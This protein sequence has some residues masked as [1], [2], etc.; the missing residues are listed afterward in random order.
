MPKE[1]FFLQG[2]SYYLGL[3]GILCVSLCDWCDHRS[4]SFYGKFNLQSSEPSINWQYYLR[5]GCAFNY[6]GGCK[7][8]EGGV[9]QYIYPFL[10][11]SVSFLKFFS[12]EG[13]I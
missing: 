12:S 8:E 9:S 3:A 6:H 1:S 11:A 5:N 2:V 7:F 10:K 4:T 13:L